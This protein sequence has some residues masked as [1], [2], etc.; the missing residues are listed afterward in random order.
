MALGFGYGDNAMNDLTIVFGNGDWPK[1]YSIEQLSKSVDWI[2]SDTQ[3][4]TV[5]NEL[6]QMVCK[7]IVGIP[8]PK[9]CQDWNEMTWWYNDALFILSNLP[10]IIYNQRKLQK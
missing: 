10:T 2:T 9:Y 3:L 5:R 1:N 4:I 7:E 8:L 6:L